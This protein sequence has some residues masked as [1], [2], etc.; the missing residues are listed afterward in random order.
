M[1]EIFYFGKPGE[2]ITDER[3]KQWLDSKGK[4]LKIKD[5]SYLIEGIKIKDGIVEVKGIKVVK[6]D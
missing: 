5:K 4:L 6:N 3:K 2:K 1:R